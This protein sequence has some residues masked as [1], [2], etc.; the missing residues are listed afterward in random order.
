MKLKDKVIVVTGGAHGIGR[1]MCLRF[2]KEQPKAIVV[3][4]FDIGQARDVARQ[5]DGM[6]VETDVASD[7]SIRSL[8]DTA[9]DAYGQIDVFC[10]NAGI[11]GSGGGIELPN[12]EWQQFIDI[13]VL[14]HLYAA[15]AVIPSMLARGEG[16]LLQ[17]VSAAGLLM[18]V[19]SA[20]YTVSKHAALA[21]AEWL[22]VTYGDAG[23]RVSALCPQGVRTRML[24]D[25]EPGA[26]AFLHATALEPEEV[27]E[28][29]VA[30]IDAEKF[31]ILPHPEVSEYVRRKGDDYER[32]LRG[33]RRL[34][35]KL[36]EV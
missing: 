13:N 14:A 7:E 34:R 36:E 26:R 20:P 11:G 30:G 15:R 18:Q 31:L 24:G 33:M 9:I 27:A 4:D 12:A 5:I 19:G 10:S 6:A 22:S 21:L 32:W 8:V 1:A 16:Y 25:A 28:T 29:V 3:A 2:A 35:E 23:I 17:T